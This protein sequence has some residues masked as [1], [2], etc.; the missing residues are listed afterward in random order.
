MEILPFLY[1][2]VVS[3]LINEKFADHGVDL[4]DVDTDLLL[5]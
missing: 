2:S 5:C 4:D 1:A 3:C